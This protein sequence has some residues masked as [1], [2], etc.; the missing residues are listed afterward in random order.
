MKILAGMKTKLVDVPKNKCFE[1]L[2]RHHGHHYY[3]WRVCRKSDIVCGPKIIK[4]ALNSYQQ[5]SSMCNE[6]DHRGCVECCAQMNGHY[7]WLGWILKRH[8][9]LYLIHLL[10]L[11]S[12]PGQLELMKLIWMLGVMIIWAKY[13]TLNIVVPDAGGHEYL[14]THHHQ[15][16]TKSTLKTFCYCCDECSCWTAASPLP[17]RR[18]LGKS[19]WNEMKFKTN[20]FINTQ[21]DKFKSPI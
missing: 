18:F 6:N 19:R 7:D 17:G 8:I 11:R 1:I 21:L 2:S 12:A 4:T 20:C 9:V 13:T 10:L 15:P 14:A 16:S 5:R 3:Y